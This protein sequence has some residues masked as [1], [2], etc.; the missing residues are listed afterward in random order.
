VPNSAQTIAF[1]ERTEALALA[2]AVAHRA[3]VYAEREACVGE[4][5]QS[6]VTSRVG[7]AGLT[8]TVT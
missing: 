5:S 1:D 2:G 6:I 3:C 8:A 7:F 4:F